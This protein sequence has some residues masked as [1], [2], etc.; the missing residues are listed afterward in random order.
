MPIGSILIGLA[1]VA[2]V[3]PIVAGPLIERK[4]EAARRKEE[5]QHDEV[6]AARQSA[7][8]ALCDLD[9]DFRT[10]KIAEEDYGPLRAQLLAEAAAADITR[11]D[12]DAEIESAVRALRAASGATS[13]SDCPECHA[14]VLPGDHFCRG[15]G[16]KLKLATVPA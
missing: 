2:L 16:A 4:K 11:T 5:G 9:F 13:P 6:E 7:L 10:G 3:A 1:L 12:R 15:C 14:A 8:I